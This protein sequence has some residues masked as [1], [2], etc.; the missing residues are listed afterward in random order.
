MPPPNSHGISYVPNRKEAIAAA[1]LLETPAEALA[2]VKTGGPMPKHYVPT[3]LIPQSEMA[4]ADNTLFDPYKK[5]SS[6]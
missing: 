5:T 1:E 2:R 4:Q 6:K 3:P